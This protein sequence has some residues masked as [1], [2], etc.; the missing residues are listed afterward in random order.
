MAK[1]IYKK[2]Q[3]TVHIQQEKCAR[4]SPSNTNVKEEQGQEVLQLPIL[5]RGL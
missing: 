2:G 3:K 4:N 5:W 1:C